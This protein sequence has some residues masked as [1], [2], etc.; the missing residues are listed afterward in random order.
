M[1]ARLLKSAGSL[2]LYF[3]LGTL[4]AQ[5]VVVGYCW[6]KWRMDRARL[7]QVL[8][9]AQGVDLM[10]LAGT[11]KPE[12]EPPPSEQPSYQQI[13]DA[14]ALRLRNLEMR[15]QALRTSLEQLRVEQQT[16]ADE[17]TRYQKQR[18]QYETQLAETAKG[19]KTA[20]MEQNLAILGRMPPRQAK[21]LLGQ[22]LKKNETN[23]VVALLRDMPD[24]GRA[25]ILKEFKTP[26]DAEKL[27]DVLR[28]IRQG[29]PESALTKKAQQQLQPDQ[30]EK[31]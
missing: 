31:P 11:P 3:A 21:E 13:V 25:K 20:G 7:L 22:M 24:A 30:P 9:V 5:A 6:S 10:T 29:R 16:L 28:Q 15:E 1:I 26:E 12:A 8:A 17:K 23:D 27:D 4:I 2:I 19:F 14:R 18:E